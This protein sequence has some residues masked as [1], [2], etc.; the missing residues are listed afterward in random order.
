MKIAGGL[1]RVVNV[2]RQAI[3]FAGRHPRAAML[4]AGLAVAGISLATGHASAADLFDGTIKLF[5]YSTKNVS[6]DC[7]AGGQNIG[8]V[9][10]ATVSPFDGG[11]KI[12]LPFYQDDGCSEYII[13]TSNSEGIKHIQV[14][15]SQ[16]AGANNILEIGKPAY[17]DDNFVP[18]A[19]IAV[20]A[21][22]LAFA[23]FEYLRRTRWR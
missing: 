11:T 12:E 15:D 3:S 16:L 17:A 4:A 2:G 1:E 18:Y 22:V 13:N 20:A 7:I 21:G 5:G 23:G 19:L 9:K 14:T 6:I 10:S 8:P